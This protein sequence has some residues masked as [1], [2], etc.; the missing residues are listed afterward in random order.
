MLLFT[1]VSH[2]ST[3]LAFIDTARAS[4]RHSAVAAAVAAVAYSIVGAQQ[5]MKQQASA[6]LASWERRLTAAVARR[7]RPAQPSGDDA[8]DGY[9]GEAAV[10]D[11]ADE[12]GGSQDDG[13]ESVAAAAAAAWGVCGVPPDV[14]EAVDA[15]LV[16]DIEEA[17]ERACAPLSEGHREVLRRLPPHAGVRVVFQHEGTPLW[18]TQWSA[19]VLQVLDPP[20]WAEEDGS[21]APYSPVEH[22]DVLPHTSAVWEGGWFKGCWEY[23]THSVVW[24]QE[25]GMFHILRRR[26]WTRPWSSP[27]A[28][29]ERAGRLREQR[30]ELAEAALGVVRGVL[31]RSEGE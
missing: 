27:S 10:A 19:A 9:G 20:A 23:S 8:D 5:H 14:R 11:S 25:C 4:A 3:Q 21:V 7:S 28:S 22:P 18:K 1:H 12:D 30:G 13:E 17:L 2:V 15:S 24:E 31:G 6:A 29:K 16:S 26:R